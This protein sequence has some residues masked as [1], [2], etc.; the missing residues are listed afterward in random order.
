[1]AFTSSKIF[2]NAIKNTVLPAYAS[3]QTDDHILVRQA[4]RT[5]QKRKKKFVRIYRLVSRK[6]PR[7]ATPNQAVCRM[8]RIIL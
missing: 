2:M 8:G 4:I 7:L 3:R 1:M 6:Q 5:K